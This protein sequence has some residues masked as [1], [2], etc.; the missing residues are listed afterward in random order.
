MCIHTRIRRI[1]FLQCII[2]TKN[3]IKYSS[4]L[5]HKKVVRFFFHSRKFVL[6]SRHV[7][8]EGRK[9][10][11]T[12]NA[13]IPRFYCFLRKEFLY[14][15]LAHQGEFVNVCVFAVASI[16][17]RA[18]AFH[19]LTDN[20]AVIWRLPL[21][22]LLTKSAHLRF[23]LTGS[24]SGIVSVTTSPALCSIAFRNPGRECR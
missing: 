21:H 14:D 13:N 4:F 11:T 8:L 10:L 18:L 2:G 16:K 23:R 5:S 17:G 3:Q 1:R 7:C 22:A 12:L 9:L 19:V 6:L 20:G 24:N 15:G